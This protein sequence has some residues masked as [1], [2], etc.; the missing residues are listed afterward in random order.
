LGGDEFAAIVYDA[1]EPVAAARRLLAALRSPCVVEDHPLYVSASIG[2]ALYPHH[3]DT[4]EALMQR[5]DVAMYR[6]KQERS[7]CALY[8]PGESH[9]RLIARRQAS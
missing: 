1:G 9:R 5:A 7:G 6:A 3:A 8:T 2:L 4:A